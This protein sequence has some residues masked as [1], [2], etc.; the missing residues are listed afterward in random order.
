[1]RYSSNGGELII[2]SYCYDYDE[3]YSASSVRIRL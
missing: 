2:A 3:V 1:M